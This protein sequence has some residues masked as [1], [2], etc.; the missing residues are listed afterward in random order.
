MHPLP[1]SFSNF[2]ISLSNSSEINAGKTRRRISE[3]KRTSCNRPFRGGDHALAPLTVAKACSAKR[4]TICTIE[5]F[6]FFIKWRYGTRIKGLSGVIQSGAAASDG[7]CF[8]RWVG[9]ASNRENHQ[10]NWITHTHTLTKAAEGEISAAYC[11]P[12]ALYMT[13]ARPSLT[14]FNNPSRKYASKAFV[15]TKVYLYCRCVH[16]S[17]H[18]PNSQLSSLS[19]NSHAA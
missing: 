16:S 15:K 1:C 10:A 4:I 6:S 3:Y 11:K 17:W 5:S 14:G 8:L 19:A 12:H 18:D 9:W 2:T 13:L 7:R